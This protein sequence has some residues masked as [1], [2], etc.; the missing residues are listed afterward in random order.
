MGE[1]AGANRGILLEAGANERALWEVPVIQFSSM[2][3]E[4]TWKSGQAVGAEGQLTK[5]DVKGMVAMISQ[6]LRDRMA[7]V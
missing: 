4:A 2:I 6:C 7:R 3:R 1:N 5:F